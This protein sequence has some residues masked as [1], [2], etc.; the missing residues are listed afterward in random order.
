MKVQIRLKFAAFTV[1]FCRGQVTITFLKFLELVLEVKSLALR[2]KSLLT[3]L[4]LWLQYITQMCMHYV[5]N[6]AMKTKLPHNSHIL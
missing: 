1:L 3:T 4:E 6:V 2:V 5:S